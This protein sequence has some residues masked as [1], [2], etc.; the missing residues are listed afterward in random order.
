MIETIQKATH[1]LISKAMKDVLHRDRRDYGY[2]IRLWNDRDPRVDQ[3]FFQGSVPGFVLGVDQTIV[4]WN[5]GFELVFGP[6]P[7]SREG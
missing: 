7:Q 2:D 6:N 1:D 4:D 5:I 3:S